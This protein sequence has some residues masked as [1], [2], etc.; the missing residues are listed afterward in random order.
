MRP[1]LQSA[2][3]RRSAGGVPRSLPEVDGAKAGLPIV[4]ARISS[5][6]K[7]ESGALLP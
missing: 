1:L 4:A 7:K 5:P 2:H 3:T 6:P